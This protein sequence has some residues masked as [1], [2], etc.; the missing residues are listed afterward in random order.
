MARKDLQ[1]VFFAI[2]AKETT[3]DGKC[4]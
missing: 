2:D 3:E 1:R 4:D